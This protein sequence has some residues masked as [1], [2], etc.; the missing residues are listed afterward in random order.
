M[1]VMK[2]P[3]ALAVTAGV[4]AAALSWA[5]GLIYELNRPLHE[6]GIGHSGIGPFAAAI[7][8]VGWLALVSI[9]FWALRKVQVA[10]EAH[11]A[12][13]PVTGLTRGGPGKR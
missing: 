2:N 6:A 10:H 7:L 13:A 9:T 8:A 12:L 4:W 3:M 1:T 5:A 11:L